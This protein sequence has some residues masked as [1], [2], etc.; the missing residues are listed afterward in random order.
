MEAYNL[1]KPD[2]EVAESE[3]TRPRVITKQVRSAQESR[4]LFIGLGLGFLGLGAIC[5]ILNCVLI[6]KMMHREYSLTVLDVYIIFTVIGLAADWIMKLSITLSGFLLELSECQVAYMGALHWWFT[7]VVNFTLI[8]LC[9]DR[10]CAI[11]NPLG[12]RSFLTV[13]R[14][15]I[16]CV[17]IVCLCFSLESVNIIVLEAESYRE[18]M[19]RCVLTDQIWYKNDVIY[20]MMVKCFAYVVGWAFMFVNNVIL[21]NTLVRHANKWDR[22]FPKHQV[23]AITVL[24]A[25]HLVL[26]LIN[27]MSSG[28]QILYIILKPDP[29]ESIINAFL[30]AD[31][32]QQIKLIFDMVQNLQV[33]V[34]GVFLFVHDPSHFKKIRQL[35]VCTGQVKENE[36]VNI[37]GGEQGTISA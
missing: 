22:E 13:K 1:F 35:C 27:A 11:S 31:K 34:V 10:K 29:A 37:T 5:L 2:I 21:I 19:Q 17:S 3:G 7:G 16:I 26:S 30:E 8:A 32:L 20:I 25:A 12:S 9:Y 23:I 36:P 4:P 24:C 6:R 14:A 33:L 28:L 15:T 18:N